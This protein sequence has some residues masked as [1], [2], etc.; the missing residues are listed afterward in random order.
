M[1]NANKAL[2]IAS[3]LAA[4]VIHS[5]GEALEA[6]VTVSSR[7]LH[8]GRVSPM[9]F[10]N[11]MELLDD[12]VPSM[13]AEM[14]NDRSFEGVTPRANWAYGDGA[15]NV[16]EREW[17]KNDSWTYDTALPFNGARSV[18]LNSTRRQPASLTQ[19]GL[20]VKTG[21]AYSFT[22]YFR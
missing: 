7:P 5:S 12:L 22:G 13:W 1:K 18:R 2:L 6:T 21:A 14:L 17:D 8:A 16:C 15:P 20:A 10:G 19:F 11:F 3:V 4:A 9:L